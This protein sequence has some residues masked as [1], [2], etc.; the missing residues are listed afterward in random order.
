MSKVAR[1]SVRVRQSVRSVERR[2]RRC[3]ARK[4]ECGGV[5]AL[6]AGQCKA[7]RLQHEAELNLEAMF[8]PPLLTAEYNI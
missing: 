3:D 7:V 1:S 5:G 6:K 8:P 4:P 2:G